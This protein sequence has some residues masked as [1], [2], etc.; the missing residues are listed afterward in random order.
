MALKMKASAATASEADGPGKEEI[1]PEILAVIA[2]AA[3]AFL[4]TNSRILSAQMQQ[5]SREQLSRWT[6][7]GWKPVQASHNVRSKR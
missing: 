1:P 5:S 6:R 2:A 4:R 3:T 7:Q